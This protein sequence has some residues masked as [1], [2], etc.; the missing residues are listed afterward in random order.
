[1]PNDNEDLEKKSD[2]WSDS[3]SEQKDNLKESF[4]NLKNELN[5]LQNQVNEWQQEKKDEQK[6]DSLDNGIIPVLES[7]TIDWMNANKIVF[8][9]HGSEQGLG[10]QFSHVAPITINKETRNKC[11]AGIARL[12]NTYNLSQKIGY[13]EQRMR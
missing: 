4:S 2:L 1:M 13:N 12:T 3:S 8:Y 10:W 7:K 9:D 6:I 5:K 11:L